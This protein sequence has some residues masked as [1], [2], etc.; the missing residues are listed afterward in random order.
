MY[1]QSCVAFIV[2]FFGIHY[3]ATYLW[4]PFQV[5]L[6]TWMHDHYTELQYSMYG[7]LMLT[8]Q[9]PTLYV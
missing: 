5:L 3:W 8:P 1:V 6:D 9:Y 2:I 4:V 7:L